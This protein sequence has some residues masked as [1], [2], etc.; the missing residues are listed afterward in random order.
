M[1]SSKLKALK[2]V[3]N[4]AKNQSKSSAIETL[5]QLCAAAITKKV[6]LLIYFAPPKKNLH[7][8]R[9]TSKSYN[10]FKLPNY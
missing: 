1:I 5:F 9:V 10:Y 2:T 4:N 6:V 3:L 8:G 7:K